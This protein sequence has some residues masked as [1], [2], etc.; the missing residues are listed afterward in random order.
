LIV[1]LVATLGSLQPAFK[2]S[3]MRPIDA[4]RHI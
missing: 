4:L 1:I 3:R 2:A